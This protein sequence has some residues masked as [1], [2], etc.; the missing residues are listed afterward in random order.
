MT[1]YAFLAHTTIN[2]NL[3]EQRSAFAPLLDSPV[4]ENAHVW[5]AD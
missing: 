5:T 1:A 2:G 4:Q 3:F